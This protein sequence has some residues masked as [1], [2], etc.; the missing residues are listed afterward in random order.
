MENRKEDARE[1][2]NV[3]F[4]DD[5]HAYLSFN[6]PV[7]QS[8]IIFFCTV[9]LVETG[10]FIWSLGFRIQRATPVTTYFLNLAV[11]DFGLLAFLLVLAAL[12]LAKDAPKSKMPVVYLL[13]FAHTV[14]LYFL[15]VVS[16]ER[17]LM[18]WFPI[19]HRSRRPKRTS[20]IVSFLVWPTA[21]FLSGLALL[22]HYVWSYHSSVM[23]I[24]IICS[25]NVLIL[26]PLVVASSLIAFICTYSQK[27]LPRILHINRSLRLTS[28][29]FLA[30]PVSFFY[31][32]GCLGYTL[33]AVFMWIFFLLTSLNSVVN[34]LIHYILGGQWERWR[35]GRT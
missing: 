7:L 13:L 8:L 33:P 29:I 6:E 9:G 30:M 21:G 25:G 12:S 1:L 27:H 31:F 15:T 16:V 35:S 4:D 17:C 24:R 20:S 18:V 26:T 14:T 19:L 2:W 11:A 32:I 23:M 22:F 34:P 3:T 5:V 10:I 28:F